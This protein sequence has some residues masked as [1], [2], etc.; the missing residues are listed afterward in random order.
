[1]QWGLREALLAL[2][3]VPLQPPPIDDND[4]EA[5]EEFHHAFYLATHIV[6][7]IGAYSSIKTTESDVPW[8][9][10]YCKNCLKFWVKRARRKAKAGG[11]EGEGKDIYV[12]VDGIAECCDVVRGLGLTEAT[13]PWLCEASIWLCDH[14]RKNGSWPVWFAEDPDGS[15]AGVYDKLHP[16]WVATQCLRDRD[17][18]VGYTRPGNALWKVFMAKLL[19][20]TNFATIEYKISYKN[21][22]AGMGNTPGTASPEGASGENAED[23]GDK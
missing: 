7:A 10:K 19:K 3:K 1:M 6:Y 23:E 15:N 14:Q 21:G 11:H 13:D 20:D 8:L 9:Y 17:F 2:R 5:R 22:T 4:E 18:E 12:D 16:S